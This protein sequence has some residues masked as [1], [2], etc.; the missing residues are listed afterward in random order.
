MLQTTAASNSVKGEDKEEILQVE[1]V[2][3]N[4]FLNQFWARLP[5]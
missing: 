5:C 2:L 4:L 1:F 3:G